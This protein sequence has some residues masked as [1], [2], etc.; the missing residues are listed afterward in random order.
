MKRNCLNSVIARTGRRVC[1][2]VYLMGVLSANG[3]ESAPRGDRPNIVFLM[4]DDQTFDSLGC[5]GNEDVRTPNIDELARDGITFDRHYVSTAI[6]MASRATVMTGKYEY[7]TGCNFSHGNLTRELWADSYPVRLREAGYRVA[8]AGKIGF[9]VSEGPGERGKPPA[10]DFDRWGAGPGQTSYDTAK[11]ASMAD[12]AETYPHSTRAYGAFGRDFIQESAASG[13]PFV[14][15][16]SFKAPHRPVTPDP[17]DDSVYAGAS[18][19]KP[20]NY[21]RAKGDHFSKQSRMGRQYERFTSWGYESEFDRVMALYHQQI[22]AVDAA[23]GMIRDALDASGV[24]SNTVVLFTSDNGFLC[25]A[26]GYGSKVL[27]YEEASRVPLI[28]YDP[29]SANSGLGLRC[30]ALT[31]NVDIAPTILELAGEEAPDGVDGKSLMTLYRDP[32]ASIHTSIPLVNVWGPK[33]VHSFAVVTD[34]WKYVY[35]PYAEGAFE[36]TEEL[37]FLETDRLELRNLADSPTAATEL[38]RLRAVY[39]ERLAHWANEGVPF[40]GYPAFSTIFDR[41]LDWET[42]R[43]LARDY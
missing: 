30:S 11:N 31:C 15:S 9:T 14:L 4:T 19:E 2:V 8:I 28:I 36:A 20:E 25:G 35:W 17:Q 26:H 24:A 43:T 12:Y 6:C 13:A 23:V 40:H 41:A 29:R 42:K 3:Q 21:G 39:E 22:Y 33:E 7:K 38:D 18:F 27:P 10:E 32:R 16:I 1:F 5:Y 37:Y 34:S